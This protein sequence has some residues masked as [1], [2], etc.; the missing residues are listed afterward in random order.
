MQYAGGIKTDGT[1][2]D[3]KPEAFHRV[4]T[5]VLGVQKR[6]VV[7]DDTGVEVWNKPCISIGKVQKDPYKRNAYLVTAYTWLVKERSKETNKPRTHVIFWHLH[8][9]TGSM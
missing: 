3:I 2:D 4:I 9:S 5:S 6:A 7:I 1:Y 8:T